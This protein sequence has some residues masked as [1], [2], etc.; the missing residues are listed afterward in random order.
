MS[1]KRQ[2]DDFSRNW[3]GE[4]FWFFGR[5]RSSGVGLVVS[6][7]YQSSVSRFVFDSNGRI[8]SALVILGLHR[9]N[10]VNIYA[11]NTVSKP[12]TFFQDLHNFFL[13]PIRII[14]GDFNSVDNL[15]D[16]LSSS[17][18]SMPDKTLLHSLLVDNSLTDIWRKQNPRGVSYTWA[19]LG[20]TQASQIDRFFDLPYTCPSCFSFQCFAL[21]FF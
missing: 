4:C 7:T 5:G 10:V 14:A 8:L 9:F 13:S 16:C 17:N 15:L 1:C 19:N 12:K 6:P 3:P 2:A 20:H 11:P 21:R 18:A